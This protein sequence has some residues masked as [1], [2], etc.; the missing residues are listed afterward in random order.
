M[1]LEDS[2]IN[3]SKEFLSCYTFVKFL[4]YFVWLYVKSAEI[5]K[6]FSARGSFN[7]GIKIWIRS[8]NIDYSGYL[9]V[10]EEGKE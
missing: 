4:Q 7:K 3:T 9:W 1:A 2:W 6:V 8:L 10:E 5:W